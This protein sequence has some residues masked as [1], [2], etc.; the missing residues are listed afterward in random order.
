[1]LLD[2]LHKISDYIQDCSEYLTGIV[3]AILFILAI[4][5]FLNLKEEIDE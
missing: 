5:A 3:L 1:M 2:T 4:Q